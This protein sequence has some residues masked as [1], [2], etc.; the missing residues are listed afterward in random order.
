MYVFLK[1]DTPAENVGS[2]NINIQIEKLSILKEDGLMQQKL[3]YMQYNAE[4]K[5]PWLQTE[6]NYRPANLG[7]TCSQHF[8]FPTLLLDK[9]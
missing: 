3:S 5:S 4:F 6:V 8:K 1:D 7:M 9:I 2:I